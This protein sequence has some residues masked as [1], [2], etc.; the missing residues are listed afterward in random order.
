MMQVPQ[1]TS[2]GGFSS[3]QSTEM[4]IGA[5]AQ[6]VVA[7][8]EI[9]TNVPTEELVR[10]LNQRLQRSQDEWDPEEAPPNYTG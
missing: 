10:I 3:P 4:P 8:V 6:P 1:R 7:T 2:L 9:D 5:G